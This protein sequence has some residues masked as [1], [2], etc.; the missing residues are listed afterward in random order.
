[1]PS[2]PAT[3]TKDAKREGRE[4]TGGRAVL[5]GPSVRRSARALVFVL[6]LIPFLWLL[7]RAA[8]GDLGAN[9]IEEITL[10]T[11][12]WTLRLLLVTLAVTPVRRLFSWNAIIRY[13]RMFGLFA[14]FYASMHLSIYLV[15]DQFFDWQTI[16]E[17]VTER[18][19][20]TAGAGAFLLLLPLAATSTTGW[21]RRLGRNWAR[22]HMLIYPAAILAVT[23]FIWKVKSDLRSPMRYAV[24]LAALLLFRVA[25]VMWVR[26]VRTVRTV[27]TL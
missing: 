17:D 4:M 13:R 15:L 5:G 10:V 3:R 1:M 7:V 22:L 21:I 14:F 24:V 27:R 25:W 6:C 9:P 19:F 18:P 23:H 2:S 8:I 16:V 26:R 20:I 12:R 11:G